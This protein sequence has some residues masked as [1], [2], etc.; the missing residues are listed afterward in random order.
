M[1]FLFPKENVCSTLHLIFSIAT[2]KRLNYTL[3]RKAIKGERRSVRK[4][5][6]VI[7]QNRTQSIKR[8]MMSRHEDGG[9]LGRNRCDSGRLISWLGEVRG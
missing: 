9:Y 7:I 3:S 2:R 8:R 6:V 4:N 5:N 1:I